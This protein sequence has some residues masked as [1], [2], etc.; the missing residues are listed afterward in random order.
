MIKYYDIIQNSRN[1]IDEK[2]LRR[3]HVRRFFL[4][5]PFWESVTSLNETNL[6][7]KCTKVV[8]AQNHP[9]LVSNSKGIYCFVVNPVVAN[10][11]PTCYLF[12]VGR[13]KGQT[14]RRRFLDY[15]KEKDSPV[16][17]EKIKDMFNMYY[18]HIYFY[19]TE[20]SDN[21]KIDEIESLLINT[22][23]PYVNT[24]IPAARIDRTLRNIY[25]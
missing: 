18:N 4:Y 20:I 16:G 10:F 14:L 6:D 19:Y 15:M 7:W 12:Y 9:D 17:R 2:A 25:E 5:P 13:S 24:H 21:Q 3:F 11:I 23:V 1:T 8:D 22:F